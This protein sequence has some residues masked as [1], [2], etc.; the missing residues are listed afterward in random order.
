LLAVRAYAGAVHFRGLLVLLLMVG[1]TL[2]AADKASS[3]LGK[4]AAA[5]EWQSLFDGR[6]LAGWAPSEF[7]T[8]GNVRVAIP[9]RDGPAA[10]MI[11]QGTT[12][13]GITWTRGSALPR[14]NYEISLEAM[15]LAGSDFFCALTFP[16]EKSACSF[17]VGGWGGTVV[18]LSSVDHSD[19]SANETTREMDFAEQRWYRIRVRVTNAKIEAWIDHEQV[20]DLETK[21]RRI[22]LRP[23]EIQK[24]L[25]LGIATYMTTAAVRN[26]RLRRLE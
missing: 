16:V 20:V 23:G 22:G 19:A 6:T 14:V 4:G 11:E 10:I 3:A 9:F 26:I 17:I 8:G 18:G 5:G 21:G 7:E 24:S 2:R 15:K 12:L 25:P 1:T 13:S